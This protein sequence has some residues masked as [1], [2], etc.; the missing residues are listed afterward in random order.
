MDHM[1]MTSRKY[2]DGFINLADPI[3]PA[4]ETSQKDHL[5]LGEAM[6]SDDREDF[7]KTMVKQIKYLTTEY[8]W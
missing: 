6:K 8:V 2:D 4:E 3:I 5:H 1:D 7:M